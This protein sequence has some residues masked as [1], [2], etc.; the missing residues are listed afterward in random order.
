MTRILLVLACV[1]ALFGVA[2]AQESV[3]RTSPIVT[4]SSTVHVSYIGFGIDAGTIVVELTDNNGA[5]T[6]KVYDATTT[7]TADA[8]FKSVNTSDNRT[9][10]LIKKVYNRLI[11]DGVITGTVSGTPQ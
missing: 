11:A 5:I 9:V 1:L 10:S 6:T 2:V 8:L 3:T 4:T 7:P